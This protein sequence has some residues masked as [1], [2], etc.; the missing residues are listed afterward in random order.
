MK[1]FSRFKPGLSLRVAVA[2]LYA[3]FIFTPSSIYLQLVIGTGGIPVSWFTLILVVE[4]ASIVGKPLTKQEALIVFTLAGMMYAP[5]WL[6]YNAWLRTSDI[7]FFFGY[8]DKIPVWVAPP[9]EV[10][11]TKLRTFLHPAWILPIT[12]A[13][14]SSVITV[15]FDFGLGIFSRELFIEQEDLP[16]PM[17]VI[18]SK[19][20]EVTTTTRDYRTIGILTVFSLVGLLWGGLQYTVPFILQAWS[21]EYYQI[22][23]IPWIDMTSLVRDILPGAIFGIG[24]SLGTFATTWILPSTVVASIVVGSFAVYFFGN[25]FVVTRGLSI[26]PWYSPNLDLSTIYQRSMM[27]FWISPL[28]GFSLAAGICPLIFKWRSVVNAVSAFRIRTPKELT[29]RR[30]D[31]L[32]ITKFALIPMVVSSIASAITYLILAPD[33]LQ[34]LPYIPILCFVLP[35]VSTLIDGRMIGETGLSVSPGANFINAIFYLGNYK[36]IN[37]WFVGNWSPFGR[38]TIDTNG[39][40]V[41][42]NLKLAQLTETRAIDYV[43]AFWL[44]WPLSIVVG[45]VFMELFWRMAP[46]PSYRYPATE[47]FWPIRAIEQSIWIGGEAVGVFQVQ[48]LI[49]AF[50]AGAGL[51]A[52]THFLPRIPFSLISFAA[53]ANTVTPIAMTLLLGEVAKQIIRMLLGEKWWNEYKTVAAAGL[54]IGEGIAVTLGVSFAVI[55]N[56]VWTSPF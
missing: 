51:Y 52:L 28:I 34:R 16:F 38:R 3:I 22:I 6:V 19:A 42:T 39:S 32:P 53:G 35:L 13:L 15:V 55:V 2:I 11:A 56:S 50:I 36:G 4:I 12:V 23:P 25:Y 48:N 33:I 54:Y 8:S 49:Y 7:A 30:T 17:Q 18:C 45:F 5:I 9:A 20:I 31:R 27:N 26:V 14:L 47:I 46:I 24:T 37:G 40:W 21:G 44:L 41:L 10:N 1:V 29:R 43:K